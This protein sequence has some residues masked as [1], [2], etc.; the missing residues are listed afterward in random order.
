MSGEWRTYKLEDVGSQIPFHR[1][2][3]DVTAMSPVTRIQD[4]LTYEHDQES[5]P[6]RRSPSLDCLG[7]AEVPWD[8]EI[9]RQTTPRTL[10][11]MSPRCHPGH[12][13][14]GTAADELLRSRRK[15][16]DEGGPQGGAGQRHR[17]AECVDAV[18][19]DKF[20]STVVVRS[21][22]R[23]ALH[24]FSSIHDR[25]QR[26]R[27]QLLTLRG[28][29]LAPAISDHVELVQRLNEADAGG[30]AEVLKR[31]LIRYQGAL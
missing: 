4:E 18:S 26:L 27:F 17:P 20:H 31:H 10:R 6:W 19:D 30:Y 11:K 13:V 16:D 2:K 8:I 3:V 24:L 15:L 1:L 9:L 29:H 28:E 21:G 22:N 12:G 7:S 5:R 25:Q 23:L 14:C